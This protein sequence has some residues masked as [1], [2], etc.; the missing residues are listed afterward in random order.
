ML[1][2]RGR[3]N[4]A[5]EPIYGEISFD[6]NTAPLNLSVTPPIQVTT[7]STNGLSNEATPD[8][9]E[10]HIIV[11]ITGVYVATFHCHVSN[12]EGTA[13]TVSIVMWGNNGTIEFPNIHAHRKLTGGAGDVGAASGGGHVYLEKGDT[14]EL[15]ATGSVD[16]KEVILEDITFY[17]EMIH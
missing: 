4:F 13:H 2:D 12:N 9:T 11:V 17:I 14:V 15:W 8:H 5:E 1:S 10:N 7:F 16:D 6:D 3:Y